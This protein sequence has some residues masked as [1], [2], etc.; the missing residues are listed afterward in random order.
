LRLAAGHQYLSGGPGFQTARPSSMT[1]A[2]FLN[3]AAGHGE[4]RFL[5]TDLSA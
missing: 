5:L 2:L 4:L 1:Q 3:K